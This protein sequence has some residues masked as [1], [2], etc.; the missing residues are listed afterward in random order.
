MNKVI[1][2]FCE[3]DHDIAFLV[4]LL[5]ANS[6]E[7]YEKKVKEFEWPLNE[8]Y[9][10]LLAKKKIEDLEFKFQRPNQKLPFTVIYKDNSLVV[11]HNLGGDGNILNGNSESIRK[12]YLDMKYGEDDFTSSSVSFDFRFLYFL[13]ADDDG[14]EYRIEQLK[15]LLELD[16]LEENILYTKDEYELGCSIFYDIGCS[17]KKGKLEN[18]LLQL[19][20]KDN[21]TI[22][23]SSKK[24]T[25]SNDLDATPERQK[26]YI[27]TPIRQTYVESRQFKKEKSFISVAGQLQF[28]GASNAVIIAN[29]D[30]IK[31]SDIDSNV[32]C[33]N[34]IGLFY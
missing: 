13:D 10:S 32:T 23:D 25:I 19:M 1:V 4:R 7:P 31:K 8:Q 30:Y 2:V 24:F 34:I 16:E 6:F 14:A 26:K 28:S 22:F 33:T 9:T 3:G 11:F 15:T 5:Y 18:I 17:D 20:E 12:M 21:E 27:C 29:S